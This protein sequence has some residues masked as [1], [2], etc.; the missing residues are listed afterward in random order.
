ML[1]PLERLYLVRIPTLLAEKSKLILAQLAPIIKTED[2]LDFLGF[3]ETI[4]YTYADHHR[5]EGMNALSSIA[6]SVRNF[7]FPRTQ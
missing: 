1:R 3:C 2:L 4:C 7:H 5:L 6:D